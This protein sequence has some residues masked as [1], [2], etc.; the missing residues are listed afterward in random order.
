MKILKEAEVKFLLEQVTPMIHFQGGE[1]GA[2]IR[3]SDL[4]PRFDAFL[5]KYKGATL[6]EYSLPVNNDG[7][8]DTNIGL[9]FD[10]KVKIKNTDCN[11]LNSNYEK[12]DF[13]AFFGKNNN[14][15]ISFYKS[16]E[17]AFI[18]P[19]K[20]LR[21]KIK[22]YFPI[23]I[24][25]NNF[26]FRNNKGYGHFKI[27]NTKDEDIIEAIK[28][29]KCLEDIY[30]KIKKLKIKKLE[31]KKL[32]IKNLKIKN[33]SK[34]NGRAIG[35]YKI[36]VKKWNKDR[37]DVIKN[38]LDEVKLFHQILKSGYNQ[39]N[40]YIPSIMLKKSKKLI[41]NEDISFEK[42]AFKLFLKNSGYD[43]PKSA[44][45]GDIKSTDNFEKIKDKIYYVRGLLGLSPFYEFKLSKDKELKSKDKELKFKVE[46]VEN[47]K[48]KNI[49]IKRFKSPITYI[50]IP[51]EQSFIIIV[52][53]GKIQMF[54]ERANNVDFFIKG[55]NISGKFSAIIPNE[56]EYSIHNIFK[57]NGV[58]DSFLKKC[59]IDKKDSDKTLDSIMNIKE[60]WFYKDLQDTE[61]DKK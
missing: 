48:I 20:V 51:N 36:E 38:I 56:K 54:R 32:K 12:I 49:K 61:V 57:K 30:L 17:I 6:K 47:K 15:K 5:S 34:C 13:G 28:K 60:N 8:E 43:I 42:K 21:E 39:G 46:N 24:A 26:G 4:K 31:I 55:N 18:S 45:N 41:P 11:N 25:V 50:P 19:H 23:F 2:G 53:Y 27:K 22:E 35:I 29:Y 3:G 37:K 10:Y 52:N 44:K 59:N 33:D 7:K 9:A 14:F 16:I 1:K 58:I 40:N